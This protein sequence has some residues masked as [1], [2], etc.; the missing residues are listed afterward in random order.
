M[1]GHDQEKL[2][3]EQN[4]GQR[5]VR[6][7]PVP[8]ASP[9]FRNRLKEE[10]VSGR[11]PPEIRP[12]PRARRTA[13][14]TV[15]VLAAAAVIIIGIFLGNQAPDWRLEG[16]MPS[17]LVVN[18][19]E[20]PVDDVRKVNDMLEPG[21]SIACEDTMGA[22]IVS[23][24]HLYVQLTT[25]SEVM[26]PETPRRWF[27]RTIEA[28]VMRGEV[29]FVTG[30]SFGGAKLM[31]ETPEVV[32]EVLGTTIAV[33]LED[34][35]TCVCVL[36]GSVKMGPRDGPMDVVEEG[37]RRTIFND[38]RPPFEEDILPMERM[39]LEMLREAS[40]P[41]VAPDDSL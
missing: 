5:A 21:N 38:G 19:E 2:T 39:K 18:G 6:S 10:F 31:V 4:L 36:D 8:E 23:P 37:R 26:L 11:I 17:T 15:G 1:S 29:R 25:S 9:E 7:L 14:L 16:P 30:E 33:I 12:A 41:S 35:G 20:M 40:V 3:P 34:F 13:L 32:I 24:G 28:E 27:G 22:T